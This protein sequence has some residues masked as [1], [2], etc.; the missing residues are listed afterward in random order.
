MEVI[1][2][3]CDA[4]VGACDDEDRRKLQ[5]LAS[6]SNDTCV[7]RRGIDTCSSRGNDA[8][9]SRG[10]DE[11]T[12]Y[13]ND[14]FVSQCPTTTMIDCKIKDLSKKENSSLQ[15]QQQLQLYNNNNNQCNG[16]A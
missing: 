9:T 8:C 14:S 12:S 15:Q 10:N 7:S 2:F 5:A 3:W 11:C 1:Y 13:N 4:E 16:K 6:H